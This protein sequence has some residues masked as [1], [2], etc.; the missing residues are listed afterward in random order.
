RRGSAVIRPQA[1]Q[2]LVR[3]GEPAAARIL[4]VAGDTHAKLALLGSEL[5]EIFGAFEDSES[6]DQLR[7]RLWPLMEDPDFPW[8]P[9][10]SRGL[11]YLPEPVEK[12]RFARY[13]DDPIAPV[14]AGVLEALFEL[15]RDAEGE[16]RLEFLRHAKDRLSDESDVVR[17]MAASQLASLG[18]RHALLWFVEDLKR[19]DTF[20]GMPMGKSARYAA[21]NALM[22]LEIDLGSY[23]PELP[24]TSA[25]N[26][27]GITALEKRLRTDAAKAE[28]KLPK[29]ERGLLIDG[30]APIAQAAPDVNDAVLGL[31]LKSCRRGD[32]F[33][34]WTSGDVLVIG[35]GNP[36]RIQLRTGATAALVAAAKKAQAPLGDQVF[37]GRPGC[38]LE[39]YY[40]PRA[41]ETL[42]SPL[43]LIIAKNEE[44]IDGLRPAALNDFGAALLA[45]IPPSEEL[46]SKDPRT[47]E[48][49]ERVREALRS[50]G[51]KVSE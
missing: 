1:A 48:L 35:F 32:F 29:K 28:T 6:G 43:N 15:S 2:R 4:E 50:V 33:L 11:S 49:A 36:A 27:D 5:I 37:W 39:G 3:I 25:M 18:H 14:R 9:A 16:A 20:F 17:R 7:A 8:R 51:G 22:D 42:P 31:Q 24:P 47:V 12:E 10:A 45:S 44:P 21:M 30:P 26:R 19:D 38:D 46:E 13:L 41:D 40:L 34:R 23:N